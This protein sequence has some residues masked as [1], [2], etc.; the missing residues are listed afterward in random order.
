MSMLGTYFPY[1][2]EE[3]KYHILYFGF[4]VTFLFQ[5]TLQFISEYRIYSVYGWV[6]FVNSLFKTSMQC[7]TAN[8]INTWNILQKWHEVIRCQL[9]GH[10]E[11]HT[12]WLSDIYIYKSVSWVREIQK[13][14][15]FVA[16]HERIASVHEPNT[17]LNHGCF[18]NEGLWCHRIT[19]P[20]ISS[21]MSSFCILLMLTRSHYSYILCRTTTCS[22]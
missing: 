4:S 13:K 11:E 1:T 15:S 18:Q 8:E 6:G 10:F 7:P 17:S 9:S 20:T 22:V 3:V 12:A 14:F 16:S 2:W 19:F 5:L 21:V